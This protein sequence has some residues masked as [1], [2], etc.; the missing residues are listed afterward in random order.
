MNLYEKVTHEIIKRLEKGVAPW[1]QPWGN[2][3]ACAPDQKFV[4]LLLPQNAETGRFYTGVNISILWSKARASP[5]W[6]TRVC[7]DRLG[8]TVLKGEAHTE[9]YCR[10]RKRP[11]KVFNLEQVKGCDNLRHKIIVSAESE[12]DFARADRII[13]RS[14]APIRFEGSR[15][16]YDVEQDTIYCPNK[17]YFTS[18]S[19]YYTTVFHE[20]TH[21]TGHPTRLDRKV[22]WPKGSPEYRLEELVCELGTCFLSAALGLPNRMQELPNSCGYLKEFID[23]LTGDAKILFQASEG[24]SH[25]TN[26]L[27]CLAAAE[28]P[29]GRPG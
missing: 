3:P 19:G 26:F 18:R 24:A 29:V 12:L 23:L 15:A 16:C 22:G 1:R 27:L 17:S 25:A 21:S 20:M 14:P 2:S 10:K 13:A 5:Y 28:L 8:A 6:A 9:V 7:W 11:Y 4:P